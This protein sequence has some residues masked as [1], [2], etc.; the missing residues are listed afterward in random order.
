MCFA[1]NVFFKSIKRRE[2]EAISVFCINK[3][4]SKRHLNGE[5]VKHKSG[6]CIKQ[7]LK[8]AFKRRELSIFKA[9]SRD[10]YLVKAALRDSYP[11]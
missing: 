8:K 10:S 1:L 6:V 11:I 9:L 3:E 2:G 5:K 7:G 4:F